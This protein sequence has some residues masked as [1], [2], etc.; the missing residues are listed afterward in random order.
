MSASLTLR[1]IRLMYCTL[2]RALPQWPELVDLAPW[3]VP[4]SM[5]INCLRRLN[6]S[7]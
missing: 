2:R 3:G 1:L 6:E 7:R 4:K 5:N